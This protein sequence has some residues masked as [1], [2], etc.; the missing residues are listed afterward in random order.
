MLSKCHNALVEV[1]YGGEGT[2]F[3]YC[4][5]CSNPCDPIEERDIFDEPFHVRLFYVFFLPIFGFV[6]M[7]FTMFAMVGSI[8][9]HGLIALA[10]LYNKRRDRISKAKKARQTRKKN[11]TS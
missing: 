3:Y 9:V 5:D 7:I 11:T 2:N 8:T 1:N 6:L 4:T 10:D